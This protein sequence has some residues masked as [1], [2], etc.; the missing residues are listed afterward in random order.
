G[1]T[2]LVMKGRGRE[3]VSREWQRRREDSLELRHVT[4]VERAQGESRYG[5]DTVENSQQCVGKTSSIAANQFWIVKIVAGVHANATRQ[6]TAHLDFSCLVEQRDF[7]P[8]DF[9]RMLADDPK[10]H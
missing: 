8:V 5:R 10:Q 9:T 7:H 1:E 2:C 6:Q 3:D 4:L